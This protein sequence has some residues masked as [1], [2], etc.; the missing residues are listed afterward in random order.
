MSTHVYGEINY[1]QWYPVYGHRKNHGIEKLEKY[2][3]KFFDDINNP[4]I[5][6][7]IKAPDLKPS[8]FGTL[9][10]SIN[11][12]IITYQEHHII[13]AS[14][15]PN[16]E[17]NETVDHI[18][19]NPKDNRIINL[20]WMS[21]SD[22]ARKGQQ[23]AVENS[24]QNGGRHGRPIQILKDNQVVG[25]F[26]SI[27]KLSRF[28]VE[29]WTYF[30]KRADAEP[31]MTKT[32]SSKIT[33]ALKN[34]SQ[35]PYG[36]QCRLIESS[37]IENEIWESI[38]D[39]KC[40]A[41]SHGRI[42]GAYNKLLESIQ[43]RCGSKYSSVYINIKSVSKRNYV[44]RLVWEA[45][46]G[47]IPDGLEILHDDEAP[48]NPD[49]S[50]RNHLEDLRLG[51]RSENMAEFHGKTGG[52]MPSEEDSKPKAEEVIPGELTK[53][54]EDIKEEDDEITK[55]MKAPPSGIQYYKETDKRGSR[56]IL[57][58]RISPTGKD[59][60]STASKKVKDR[61]KFIEIYEKYKSIQSE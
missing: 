10:L 22:N 30:R 6:K 58:R 17:P 60:A 46:N 53:R 14:A 37:I 34:E 31:P 1:D 33:R 4:Y 15:F 16:Q 51:T 42:K 2:E 47:P 54:C 27:E 43:N 56:Y 45:F 57:S 39:S 49:G 29:N 11:N 38:S 9:S 48:L 61:E 21:W 8:P 20:Q 52:A 55:L 35:R 26:R 19:N 5:I 28:I 36:L 7:G 40:Q 18:N 13:L 3:I 41:S 59:I 24:K 25:M 50:Y 12:K 32:I 23:K 44:H